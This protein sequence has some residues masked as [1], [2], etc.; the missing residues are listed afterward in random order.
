[1]FDKFPK[2]HWKILLGE[3]NVE[4]GSEDILKPKLK[5]GG[6]TKAVMTMDLE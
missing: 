5:M 3:F 6:F 4:V 1:V 2:C